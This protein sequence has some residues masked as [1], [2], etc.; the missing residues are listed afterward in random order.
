MIERT[1]QNTNDCAWKTNSIWQLCTVQHKKIIHFIRCITLFIREIYKDPIHLCVWVRYDYFLFSAI[2]IHLSIFP[3][4]MRFTSP[5]LYLSYEMRMYFYTNLWKQIYAH[6]SKWKQ[7]EVVNYMWQNRTKPIRFGSP[8]LKL[9]FIM[10]VMT[11][12]IIIISHCRGFKSQKSDII[13][14]SQQKK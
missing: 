1:K 14:L 3:S 2:S 13:Q 7:I 4:N 11:I 6:R 12:V 9:L 5:F 10:M 8:G